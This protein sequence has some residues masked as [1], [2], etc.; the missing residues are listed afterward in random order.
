[1][2][3]PIVR[4]NPDEL[5]CSDP[6]MLDEIYAGGNRP[7]DKWEHYAG[8]LIGPLALAGFATISHDIHRIRKGALARYFSRGQMLKLE[9]EVRDFTVRT[10]DKMLRRA[11]S[12]EFDVK[13]AFNCLTAD[14]ISQYCFGESMGFTDQAGFEP[15]FG[16]WVKYANNLSSVFD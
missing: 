8:F 9:G 10:V 4:I 12:G 16:T 3:G 14:I 5:H 2:S 15:N 6:D 11:G 7:R 13:E 1:M